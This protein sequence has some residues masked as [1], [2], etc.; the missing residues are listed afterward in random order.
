MLAVPCFTCSIDSER[1]MNPEKARAIESETIGGLDVALRAFG[2]VRNPQAKR[3]FDDGHREDWTRNCP[4]KTEVIGMSCPLCYSPIMYPGSITMHTE[5]LLP[6]GDQPRGACLLGST[7][8]SLVNRCSAYDLPTTLSHALS[9][10][11]FTKMVVG[12]TLGALSW[13]DLHETPSVCLGKILHGETNW[14]ETRGE[15]VR[16]MMR[17]L[18]GLIDTGSWKET[19]AT[20]YSGPGDVT[21]QSPECQKPGDLQMGA[22]KSGGC[23]VGLRR[24]TPD[25]AR[26][27][28][29]NSETGKGVVTD[30]RRGLD[31][32]LSRYGFER[33]TELRQPRYA[34]CPDYWVRRQDWRYEVIIMRSIL[35]YSPVVRTSAIQLLAEIYLPCT[36][37]PMGKQF[38]GIAVANLAK[39]PG[40]YKIPSALCRSITPTRFEGAVIRDTLRALPWFDGFSSPAVCLDHLQRGATWLGNPNGHGAQVA[41]R[42]LEGLIG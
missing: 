20:S 6:C 22:N 4:W 38:H 18:A 32:V 24:P 27:Y 5:I 11:G 14:G 26:T 9:P 7:V 41:R 13:F 28:L 3:T 33:N 2:F 8:G 35:R 29:T 10:K 34:F 21:V 23:Q 31:N 42:Y 1:M 37:E 19:G 17:Y 39:R 40:G 12:D 16:C 15:Q 30:L 25:P 36:G